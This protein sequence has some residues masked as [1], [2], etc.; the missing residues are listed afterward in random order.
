MSGK[1]KKRTVGVTLIEIMVALVVTLV[2]II[3][4]M[5]YRYYSILDARKAKVQVTGTRLCSILLESWRSSGGHSE[6]TDVFDPLSYLGYDLKHISFESPGVVYY[7]EWDTLPVVIATSGGGPAVPTGFRGF[8]RYAVIVDGA[9]YY[10]TM[11]YD[12]DSVNS[13]RTLNAC[14]AWPRDYPSGSYSADDEW[15]S[16][17]TRVVTPSSG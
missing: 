1:R 12:D 6:P 14:V 16:L 11:A 15:V 10:V 8:G 13:L 5:G 9:T 17:T 3:G 4:A 2:A 7:G